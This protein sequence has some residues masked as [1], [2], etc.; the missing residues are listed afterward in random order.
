M[1]FDSNMSRSVLR[2][3]AVIAGLCF[4]VGCDGTLAGKWEYR[5]IARVKSPDSPYEAVVVEGGG[6][7]TTSTVTSVYIVPSGSRIHEKDR[8]RSL[9]DAD[10]MSGFELK[11][12]SADLL[13]I[14]YIEARIMGFRN[15]CY[16]EGRAIEVQLHPAST[17]YALPVRDRIR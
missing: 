6:G 7:A 15:F 17:N 16:G 8:E 9:F 2:C 11:W 5:E 1:S 13:Q 4:S 10:H 3:F 14:H 12:A